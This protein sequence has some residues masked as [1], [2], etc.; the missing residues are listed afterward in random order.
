MCCC[1]NFSQKS[2]IWDVFNIDIL[3][4][5]RF[6]ST[7]QKWTKKKK[8]LLIVPSCS[9]MFFYHPLFSHLLYR[10]F[11]FVAFFF[12]AF[13]LSYFYIV[14]S[15]LPS[16]IYSIL[17]DS[18]FYYALY[19]HKFMLSIIFLSSYELLGKYLN[20]YSTHRR[21]IESTLNTFF[22][23]LYCMLNCIIHKIKGNYDI[24]SLTCIHSWNIF[25]LRAVYF[26]P[27]SN[28]FH[29]LEEWTSFDSKI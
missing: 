15:L 24:N 4:F 23:I 21:Y 1:L 22:L 16:S 27:Y 25:F 20:T 18:L 26:W 10:S 13:I 28:V 2:Y 19:I 14:C 29:I 7:K 3:S 9:Y 5:S 12:F 6:K 17:M 8:I 11:D